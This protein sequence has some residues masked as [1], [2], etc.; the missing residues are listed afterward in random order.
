[1]GGGGGRPGRGGGRG[2]RGGGC[3]QAQPPFQP[4]GR[5]ARAVVQHPS[6]EDRRAAAVAA[7][8][9]GKGGRRG[10]GG[11]GRTQ[12]RDRPLPSKGAEGGE[13]ARMGRCVL[14]LCRQSLRRRAGGCSVFEPAACDRPRRRRQRRLGRQEAGCWPLARRL[15]CPPLPCTL[16]IHQQQQQSTHQPPLTTNTN[17]QQRHHHHH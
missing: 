13:A 8:D 4:A 5:A 15:L 9:A 16:S 17:N 10:G 1:M 12:E 6:L 7:G 3:A 2:G 11:R 14:P